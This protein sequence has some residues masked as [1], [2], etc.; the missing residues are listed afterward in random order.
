MLNP[1]I[2]CVDDNIGILRS[3][4]D[5]L[6]RH[7]HQGCTVELATNGPEA[8]KLCAE[9]IAE[10]IDIAVVI[11]D[12]QMPGMRGDELLAQIHRQYPQAMTIMLTGNQEVA[13]IRNA[14]NA[15]NLYR[16]I[17]KP[18][19]AEDLILTV[20]EALRRFSQDYKLTTQQQALKVA[21]TEL[22]GSLSL[23][24]ATL[25]ATADG[26]LVLDKLGQVTHF[27]QRLVDIW[28]IG[29]S[30]PPSV[31][32]DAMIQKIQ[33]IDPE[34]FRTWLSH[35]GW[36]SEQTNVL[37]LKTG[38][39][40]ECESHSQQLEQATIGQVW[41]F[42]DVTARQN[43]EDTIRYQASHDDLTGLVNRRQFN[44]KL[45][46]LLEL[47]EAKQ[48][49]LAVLFVDL[50]RFKLVN[51][52]LGHV[53][54][55]R[56]LQKVVDRLQGSCRETDIIARWGGDEFTLAL[57]NIDNRENASLCAQRILDTLC[58]SFE[59]DG[60]PICITSSIGIALYPEDG[61]TADILL[62][63]ADTAL[64]KVKQNGRNGY[65]HYTVAFNDQGQEQLA[66]EYALSQALERQEISVYYQPQ[67]DIQTNLITH[68]EALAR[69][70][71][72]QLGLISP[73]KFIPIAEENG[74]IITL[75]TWIL[76]T[77]CQQAKHW[78]NLGFPVIVAVNLSPRQLQDKSLSANIQQVLATT[79]LSQRFLELEITESGALPNL[80]Q[81]Q[82]ILSELRAMGIGIA[83]DDFGTG[84]SSLS[85][86]K[87]F[88]LDAIKIDRSF[89]RDLL[90]EPGD[91]AIAKAILD[92]G[93]GLNLRVVT[94]GVETESLKNLLQSLH[95]RQMQGYLFS[96]PLPAEEA[97]QLL[98]QTNTPIHN[99]LNVASVTDSIFKVMQA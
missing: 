63:N 27:N 7:F 80:T 30:P 75:G 76:K 42:R 91:V 46:Q 20:K 37:K 45:D 98:L 93:R 71:H 6:Q 48:E 18:W 28:E 41:S 9:L 33:V 4:G 36:P 66:L 16:Y 53:L 90:T 58:P 79:G 74:F 5:Q 3:L 23:L 65:Q 77:A 31:V 64:Y 44:E 43:A 88:P 50:D 87:Q 1:A 49:R 35:E 38:R 95:C 22:A 29:H 73:E 24:Q 11:S 81:T 83:L 10:G 72:P 85:Y 69:W 78:Q 8:L 94:E 21:N 89:V 52:S 32:L 57:P 39:F 96:R 19:D 61:E 67:F 47:S 14:V 97:T 54:G 84:Y 51:D 99:S 12:Q 17:A 26:I 56:L 25:N 60:Y 2:I 62:Q 13:T 70:H 15:A 68:M 92:L 86:L 82:L 34:K 59:L 55:D 40:I